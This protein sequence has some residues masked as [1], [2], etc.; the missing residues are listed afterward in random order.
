MTLDEAI[1]AIRQAADMHEASRI[2]NSVGMDA[3]RGLRPE[4]DADACRAAFFAQWRD[5][6]LRQH[7]QV[8]PTPPLYWTGD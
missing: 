5:E 3:M 7:T 2:N 4:S 1:Q 6:V 8:A